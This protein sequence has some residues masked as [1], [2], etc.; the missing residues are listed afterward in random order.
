MIIEK[1]WGTEET[2]AKTGKYMGKILYINEG[3]RLSLKYHSKKEH[4]IYVLEGTLQLILEETSIRDK[5]VLILNVGSSHHIEPMTI[6]RFAATQGGAVKL[7]EVSTLEEDD[8][9]RIED[10]YSRK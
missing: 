6:H 10:D 2:W 9:V 4:T 8:I 3:Q 1:P 7:I 5:E